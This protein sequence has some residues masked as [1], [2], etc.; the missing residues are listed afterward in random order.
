VCAI[1]IGSSHGWVHQRIHEGWNFTG[2]GAAAASSCRTQNV[3]LAAGAVKSQK[4]HL[5]VHLHQRRNPRL[6]RLEEILLSR[7]ETTPGEAYRF[8]LVESIHGVDVVAQFCHNLHPHAKL[9]SP[10]SN[11]LRRH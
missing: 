1:S 6:A 5:Y 7:S 10:F 9:G 8:F 2:G 4:V 3:F 11:M